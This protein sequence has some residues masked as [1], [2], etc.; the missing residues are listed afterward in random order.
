[1]HATLPNVVG[2]GFKPVHAE[3]LMMDGRGLDFIEVHA[4]NLTGA[5]GSV[6]AQIDAVRR[7][8]PLSVQCVG[9]SIGGA[10]PLDADHLTRLATVCAR[11]EAA[12]VSAHLAWS[13]HGGRFFNYLLP[14]A[15]DEVTLARVIAHVQQVQERLGRQLLI[16]NSSTYLT[17]AGSAMDEVDFLAALVSRSACGLLLDLNNVVV[18]QRSRGQSPSDCLARFPV[19]AVGQLHL[20]GHARDLTEDGRMLRI[21]ASACLKSTPR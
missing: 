1:M 19:A 14:I 5:G 6:H 21:K 12:S 2:I 20:P 3:V 18:S 17:L 16:E 13:S 9:L 10:E 8:F 7:E 15:Y 4:E 11:F